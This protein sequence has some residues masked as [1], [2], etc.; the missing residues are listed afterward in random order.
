MFEDRFKATEDFGVNLG[1]VEFKSIPRE[2][3]LSMILD[4]T[5]GEVKK[6]CDNVKVQRA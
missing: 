5:K 6:L 2:T 4:F 3:S 1:F